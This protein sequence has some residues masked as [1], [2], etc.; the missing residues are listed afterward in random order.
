MGQA[1]Q[2]IRDHRLYKQS[3][4]TFEAYVARRW[5]DLGGHKY[6]YR[7]IAAAETVRQLSPM[8]DTLPATERQARPLTLLDE[9]T[10]RIAAWQRA[11]FGWSERTARN[12][13]EV[14]ERFKSAKFADLPAPSVL[15][16]LAQPNT[17][18]MHQHLAR[19]GLAGAPCAQF[20]APQVPTM[21]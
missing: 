9:P 1:L 17:P 10:L 13:M 15:Y 14:A 20:T 5:P 12:F 2:H 21:G 11:E 16:L 18:E 19:S 6:A 4:A 8:G 3:D 7:V